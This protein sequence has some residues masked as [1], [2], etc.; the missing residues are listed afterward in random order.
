[1]NVCVSVTYFNNW[2]IWPLCRQ[3]L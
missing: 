3:L 1:M 2:A